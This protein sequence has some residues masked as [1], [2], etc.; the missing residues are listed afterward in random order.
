MFFKE[1]MSNALLRLIL[2]YG[3]NEKVQEDFSL[4]AT[5]LLII[6]KEQH[7]EILGKNSPFWGIFL[8]FN[9]FML[10]MLKNEEKYVVWLF[11]GCQEKL[12]R[13][14]KK[15]GVNPDDLFIKNGSI[16]QINEAFHTVFSHWDSQV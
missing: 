10:K 11:V 16:E 12:L 2:E 7:E 9:S 15:Y 8:H 4:L 6:S 13:K 14:V 5:K 1:T 3:S